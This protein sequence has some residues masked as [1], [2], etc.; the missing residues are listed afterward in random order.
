MT[1]I[2]V[3]IELL[4]LFGAINHIIVGESLPTLFKKSHPFRHFWR[5]CCAIFKI[6]PRKTLARIG[7]I[8][9]LGFLSFKITCGFLSHESWQE[10]AGSKIFT[11]IKWLNYAMPF[12]AFYFF[13]LARPRKRE[14]R[15]WPE[16]QTEAYKS[17]YGTARCLY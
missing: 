2:I 1:T 5:M 8:L 7:I 9:I 3:F 6:A 17:V 11:S 4:V 14:P 12:F 16:I 10:I 13:W 15:K